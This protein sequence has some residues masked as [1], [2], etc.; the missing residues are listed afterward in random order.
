M[1]K[2]HKKIIDAH[3]TPGTTMRGNAKI[4]ATRVSFN[5]FQYGPPLIAIKL[6]G[7]LN[8][9]QKRKIWRQAPHMK[10]KRA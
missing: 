5:P 6:R 1:E 8:Q 3:K 4:F 7:S 9:K 2:R 10:I